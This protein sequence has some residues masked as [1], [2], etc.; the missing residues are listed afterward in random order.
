MV[1]SDGKTKDPVLYRGEDAVQ[2][3]LSSLQDKL[4][5]IREVFRNPADIVMSK[6]DIKKL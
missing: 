3:L 2:H 5:E 4:E 6:E 1:R